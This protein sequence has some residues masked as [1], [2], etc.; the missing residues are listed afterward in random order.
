M[1]PTW[2]KSFRVIANWLYAHAKIFLALPLSIKTTSKNLG[3]KMTAQ[4]W[5]ACL[6]KQNTPFY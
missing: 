5:V 3:T 6:G 4:A 1:R 2:P